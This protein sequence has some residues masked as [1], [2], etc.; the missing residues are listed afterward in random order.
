MFGPYQTP[1]IE[2]LH[3]TDCQLA[4]TQEPETEKPWRHNIGPGWFKTKRRL[5]LLIDNMDE[6]K[7]A[8]EYL[9]ENFAQQY[10]IDLEALAPV[11][12]WL[13]EWSE[14]PD[15][16]VEYVEGPVEPYGPGDELEL[17]DG[18]CYEVIATQGLS[19]EVEHQAGDGGLCYE[20]RGYSYIR[21]IRR[22][23]KSKTYKII[24]F[25]N[26]GNAKVIRRGLSLE[27]AQKHCRRYDTHGPGWFD[28][29]H[30]EEK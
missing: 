12:D 23:P 22:L 17:N 7:G 30:E 27:E 13:E 21:I 10:D 3:L 5:Q 18:H 19:E 29:Y 24:R 11:P 16:Y 9:D 1:R 28:G 20:N 6:I 2:M 25:K 26:H 4:R 15:L 8:R 14:K